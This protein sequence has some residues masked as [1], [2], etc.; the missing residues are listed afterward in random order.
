MKDSNL[1]AVAAVKGVSK[2]DLSELLVKF[3][4]YMGG[5]LN[6]RCR[7][8]ENP[9]KAQQEYNFL[10]TSGLACDQK[11]RKEDISP[12]RPSQSA[13]CQAQ[14]AEF[15]RLWQTNILL[16]WVPGKGM[17]RR[18][19]LELLRRDILCRRRLCYKVF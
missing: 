9:K 16:E 15:R 13:M 5:I 14:G 19:C 12:F 3:V 17:S 8:I 18:R 4:Q 6:N 2:G 10:H 11:N 1:R 7:R